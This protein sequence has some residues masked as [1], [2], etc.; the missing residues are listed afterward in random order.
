MIPQ[1]SNHKK[2]FELVSTEPLKEMW[3]HHRSGKHGGWYPVPQEIFNFTC[4]L[5][6]LCS[7][8]CSHL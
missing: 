3:V 5:A 4:S 2:R 7:G 6:L 8:P 1:D